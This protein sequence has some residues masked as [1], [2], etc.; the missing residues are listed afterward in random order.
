MKK[1][2]AV[3]FFNCSITGEVTMTMSGAA[4][5]SHHIPCVMVFE[6]YQHYGYR[7]GDTFG[8]LTAGQNQTVRGDTPPNS[9]GK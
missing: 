7:Q 6:A 8:T 4:T 5:D 1:V 2:I 3:D 9:R